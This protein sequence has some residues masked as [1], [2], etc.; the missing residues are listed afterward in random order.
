MTKTTPVTDSGQFTFRVYGIPASKGSYRP[1][2][3]R[4]HVD[5]RPVTRLIPMDAKEK[6]WRQRIVNTIKQCTNIPHITNDYSVEI[7]ETFYL[8]RPQTIPPHKR[9]EPTVKPDLDKLQ[10]ALHD[11]LTDSGIITDD[12]LITS[13]TAEKTY[14]DPDTLEGNDAAGVYVQITWSKN[15][16]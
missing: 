6:P 5:G 16:D 2:T 10:R 4:S 9:Y 7:H 14:T 3:G 1:I 15:H 13:I 8:P 11:A 12:S